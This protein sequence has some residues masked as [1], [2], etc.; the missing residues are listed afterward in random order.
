MGRTIAI[1]LALA[2]PGMLASEPTLTFPKTA[3]AY[4]SVRSYVCGDRRQ[5]SVAYVGTADGDAFAYLPAEGRPHIF[6]RVQ[7]DSGN[8]YVSGP[9]VW[10]TTGAH[11][12][13]SRIDDAGA[14][15][16]LDDCD[17]VATFASPRGD[18]I[19]IGTR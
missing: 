2:S 6:V 13:L 12:S 4:T 19:E 15:P 16:L 18:R 11:G 17:A 7:A 1:A 5:V 14:P 9:Y 3:V 8:R 10:A